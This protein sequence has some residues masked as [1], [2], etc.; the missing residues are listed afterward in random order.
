MGRNLL[1]KRPPPF[2][3]ECRLLGDPVRVA[4]EWRKALDESVLP[5]HGPPGSGKT[6]TGASMVGAAVVRQK[7]GVAALAITLFGT[8]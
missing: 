7:V 8:C 4:E 2:A 5:I 3:P 6:S 1:L